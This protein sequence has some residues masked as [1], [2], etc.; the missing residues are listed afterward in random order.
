MTNPVPSTIRPRQQLE[1]LP[2]GIQITD[3]TYGTTTITSPVLLALIR[4]P[5]MQRLKSI[6]QHGIT[7]LIAVNRVSPPLSRFEHSLGAMLLVRRLAPGD[8][9]QQCA[10]LL[11]DVSHTVLSHVTDYAFGYVIHEV[12]KEEYVAGTDLPRILEEF[13][14]DWRDITSEE[15]G[16]WPLLEQDAP[17]L[18]ADRLDYSLRDLYAFDVLRVQQIRDIMAQFVVHEDRIMCSDVALAGTLGRGYIRC[19]Q[20][21]WSNPRHS[22]LYFFAGKAIRLALQHDVISKDDLWRGTDS[23]F[24]DIIRGCNVPEVERNVKY[25]SRETKFTRVSG[26]RDGDNVIEI[27]LRTRTIDPEVLIREGG[28]VHVKRLTELDSAFATEREEYI[29]SKSGSIYLAVS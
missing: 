12:E 25:V 26:P 18:C 14:Y 27:P 6:H 28:R 22:G 2:H 10:A 1:S 20:L 23:Q 16:K 29:K 19:D 8:L 13:G 7:P 11:H 24:W 17:L 15:Q 3:T 4:S 21:A 9:A 5:A